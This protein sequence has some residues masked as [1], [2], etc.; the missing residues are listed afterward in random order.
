MKKIV[1]YSDH[2][3]IRGTGITIFEF[4]IGC[5]DILGHDVLCA[6]SRNNK[7]NHPDAIKKFEDHGLT[8]AWFDD[9]HQAKNIIPSLG[10][11]YVFQ[12]RSEGYNPD[13][14]F[15]GMKNL[16]QQTGVRTPASQAYGHRYSHVSRW[17]DKFCG[18]DGSNAVPIPIRL[19]ETKEDLREELGIPKEMTIFA[20]TGGEDTWN[21]WFAN[22]AIVKALEQNENIG[23]LFQNTPNVP[24]HPRIFH[25]RTTADAEYKRKFINTS[26]F[27]LHCR[28]EGESFGVA[29][30]EF[31]SANKPVIT[32]SES[33]ERA[34][35]DYLGSKM[36][37][38]TTE[39]QL[40]NL[41]IY[42]DRGG[43]AKIGDWNAY[44]DFTSEKIMK[45]FERIYLS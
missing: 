29:V 22:N 8:M 12:I 24:S 20:R 18:G 11:E 37:Q 27:M 35:I 40:V 10:Y 31:S 4:A 16:I 25:A 33:R 17:V 7:H 30:A 9:V 5:R 39:D 21:L 23:F 2:C 1:F 36:Y 44:E 14:D 43:K 19:H 38:Y 3:D 32:W 6:F 41:L 26:D 45:T 13:Y 15:P 34:H 42:F 28:V